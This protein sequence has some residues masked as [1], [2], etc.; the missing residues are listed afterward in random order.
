V[1]KISCGSGFHGSALYQFELNLS[2]DPGG[3]RLKIPH[4]PWGEAFAVAL[5]QQVGRAW[6]ARE[7]MAVLPTTMFRVFSPGFT[8]L[9]TS[10]EQGGC[11]TKPAFTP[12]TTPERIPYRPVEISLHTV[13]R[14]RIG[15][16]GQ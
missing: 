3:H 4:V 6:P 15:T 2:E 8:S 11:Q 9:V 14:Q 1:A 12:L 5:V 10:S 13:I 16:P 7:L